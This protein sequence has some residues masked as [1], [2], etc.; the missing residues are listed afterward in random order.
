MSS[1][2][3][4]KK[5]KRSVVEIRYVFLLD[6]TTTVPQLSNTRTTGAHM[7][8]TALTADL[9]VCVWGRGPHLYTITLNNDVT[10]QQLED[11][12]SYSPC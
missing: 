6:L 1:N 10:F 4:L 2:V 3:M 8:H 9:S 7:Q 5:L 12:A 11:K